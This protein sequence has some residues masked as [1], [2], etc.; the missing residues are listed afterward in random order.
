M[1]INTKQLQMAKRVYNN[2]MEDIVKDGKVIANDEE[3]LTKIVNNAFTGS[4][5]IKN[6]QAFHDLNQLIVTTA[7]DVAK[8]NLERAI[9]LVASYKTVGANDIMEYDVNDKNV[10]TTMALSATGS[11]VDFVKIP[12]YK[13]KIFATPKK[14]QFGVKYS[15]SAMVSDPVNEFR[16][17]VN[18]V[19]EAKVKYIMSQ[20]YAVTRS[21]VANSKIPAKQIKQGAGISFPEFRAVESSLLRYGRNVRPVLIADNAF[22]GTLAEKQATVSVQGIT[23][24]P[25]YLTDDLK[26][27][28]LR[29]IEID[30][31]SKTMCIATDNPWT[32]RMN[33]KVDLPVDEAIMIAGGV[34]SP[35]KVTEFGGMAVLSDDIDK[36]IETEEVFMKISYKVDVTLLLNRAIAYLKDTSVVL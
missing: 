13:N 30:Q 15:I 29:D 18:Y 9:N 26:E 7:D 5:T 10:Q 1:E 22:I 21:A 17:A 24:Q 12:S 25:L 11:G 32:D 33:T 31:I 19:A 16:N 6:Y 4:N 34:N 8:P 23:S 35:F 2:K 14:H 28:L 20:L 36:H 27:S 3:A